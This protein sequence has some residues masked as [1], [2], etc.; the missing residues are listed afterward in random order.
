[1]GAADQT[2]AAQWNSND[3][4]VC[5]MGKGGEHGVSYVIWG[6]GTQGKAPEPPLTKANHCANVVGVANVSLPHLLADHFEA[7]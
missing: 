2:M 1:M 6:A 3:A 5:C 4:D 7:A